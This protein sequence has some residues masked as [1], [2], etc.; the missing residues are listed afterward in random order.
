MIITIDGPAG[1]GKTSV[2][3]ALAERLGYRFL[4]TGAMYRSVIWAAR[5]RGIELTDDSKLAEVARSIAIELDGRHAR[6]D[7]QDVTHAIR[8]AEITKL[9]RRA[10]DNVKVRAILSQRQRQMAAEGNVVTE[11]RDQGTIVFPHAECKIFLTASPEERA[12]RRLL[13]MQRRGEQTTFEEVLERQNERDNQDRNRAVGHLAKAD[14]AFEFATDGL[15]AEEV[16]DRLEQFVRARQRQ[17][18][19]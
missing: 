13:D 14:D 15:S 19:K 18:L 16:L 8:A 7:G 4:D 5:H 9:V 6:V 10:A 3:R 11:G 1:A 2:A 12:R 17:L